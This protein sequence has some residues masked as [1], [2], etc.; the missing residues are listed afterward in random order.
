MSLVVCPGNLANELAG[1]RDLV[2]IR[3]PRGGDRIAHRNLATLAFNSALRAASG[4]YTGTLL[5]TMICEAN[6]W[7]FF[8]FESLPAKKAPYLIDSYE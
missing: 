5:R 3:T 4:V 8:E 1:S 2:P 7:R 6:Q